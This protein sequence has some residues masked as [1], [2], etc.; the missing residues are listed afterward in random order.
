M[1]T[2]DSLIKKMHWHYRRAYLKQLRLSKKQLETPTDEI[3]AELC[4]LGGVLR[5]L[6]KAIDLANGE[7]ADTYLPEVVA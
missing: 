4:E 1:E 2:F 7:Q 6:K 3:R 5:G